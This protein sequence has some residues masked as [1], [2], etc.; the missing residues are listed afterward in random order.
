MSSSMKSMA[1]GIFTA[2]EKKSDRTQARMEKERQ[3]RIAK[4][5]KL[6]ALR[7]AKEAADKEAAATVA[8]EK[9]ARKKRK[10]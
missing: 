7:L 6:R 8:S 10:S 4:N 9:A 3:E 5:D 1:G 2:S